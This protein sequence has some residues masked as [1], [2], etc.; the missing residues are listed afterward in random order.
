[1]VFKVFHKRGPESRQPYYRFTESRGKLH[2]EIREKLRAVV[3]KFLNI[4]GTFYEIIGGPRKST[5][6][7]LGISTQLDR[8]S[9]RGC[10]LHSEGFIFNFT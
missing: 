8:C 2:E 5:G 9:P 10:L 7:T 3:N 4:P 6:L 1:M